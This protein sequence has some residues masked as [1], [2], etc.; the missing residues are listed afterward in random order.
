MAPA[1]TLLSEAS[2]RF[3]D[4]DDEAS[5]AELDGQLARALFL[6]GRSAEAIVVADRVLA[7]AERANLVEI[8]ADTLISRGSALVNVGRLFEGVG[9]IE[10]GQRLAARNSMPATELRALNNLSSVL[11]D[12]DPRAGLEAAR[13]GLVVS[14]RLGRRTFTIV[15]NMRELALRFGEW[16]WITSELETILAGELDPFDRVSALSGLMTLEAYRGRSITD[17]L[18]EM[19]SIEMG[20]DD[21]H[22][23]GAEM[24]LGAAV[25][26]AAGDYPLARTKMNALGDHLPQGLHHARLFGARC[27]LLAGH[28][29]AAMEDLEV[30]ATSGRRGRVVDASSTTI[31]AGLAALDGRPRDAV[32]LYRD[33]LREW[34][35][36]GQVWDEALCAIDMARLLGPDEPDVIA[37]TDAARTILTDLEARPFL[38]RLDAAMSRR[39]VAV[40]QPVGSAV[41]SAEVPTAESRP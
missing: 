38:D 30:V 32:G 19:E 21:T 7:S 12:D 3:A 41:P 13:A 10:T 6:N 23:E 14:R 29:A 5:L 8:V 17:R 36:I 40:A 2:E 1:L 28:P 18:A 15:E 27:A 9:A 20:D 25:A 31:L 26:F 39:P 22:L 4:L 24:E 11:A 33:A 37:A 34:R 16:D 35:D